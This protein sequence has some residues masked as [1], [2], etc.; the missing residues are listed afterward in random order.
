MLRRPS[1]HPFHQE[2]ISPLRRRMK[3]S[4]ALWEK[5]VR[6]A[7]V[8]SSASS[9]CSRLLVSHCVCEKEGGK[10]SASRHTG[11]KPAPWHSNQLTRFVIIIRPRKPKAWCWEVFRGV[12]PPDQALSIYYILMVMPECFCLSLLTCIP[13]CIWSLLCKK[14]ESASPNLTSAKKQ[15]KTNK[16]SIFPHIW[17]CTCAS[18]TFNHSSIKFWT[19]CRISLNG[20]VSYGKKSPE[21]QIKFNFKR[22]LPY[23]FHI[24]SYLFFSPLFY[25]AL[26]M[27]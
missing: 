13:S 21:W 7:A 25:N 4:R 2:K 24:L 19:S 11:E 3:R 27:H 12:A 14:E 18:Q 1:S 8:R 9:V 26:I 23:W 6:V 5:S 22:S 15:K 16:M 20:I 17:M 10:N